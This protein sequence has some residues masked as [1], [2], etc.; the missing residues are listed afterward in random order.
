MPCPD[1]QVPLAPLLGPVSDWG[2]IHPYQPKRLYAPAHPNALQQI[3]SAVIDGEASGGKMK[4]KGSNYS[5]SGAQ[6]TDDFLISTDGLNMH[7]SQ[8]HPVMIGGDGIALLLDASRVANPSY[9]DDLL[10]KIVRPGLVLPPGNHLIHVEAGIKIKQLLADLASVNLALP[11]M[12]AGGGQSLA[13]ALSTGTHGSDVQL[14]PLGD[15]VRAVHIVGPKGQEWWITPADNIVGGPNLDALPGWCPDT[16][17]VRDDDWFRA[18]LLTVGRFGVV[19]SMILE[20]PE[21]YHLLETTN[22]SPGSSAGMQHIL[23]SDTRAQLHASVNQGYDSGGV[24]DAPHQGEPLRFFSVL[25]DL[26]E[27]E[28]CWITRRWKTDDQSEIGISSDPT[29]DDILCSSNPVMVDL[30]IAATAVFQFLGGE[31]LAVP[32]VGLV[33]ASAVAE[34]HTELLVMAANSETVADFLAKAFAKI[35]SLT[36]ELYGPVAPQLQSLIKR[37]GAVLLRGSQTDTRQGASHR[38]LDTHDYNRDGCS[39]G[40]SSEFFFDAQTQNYLLFI[41]AVLNK[42]QELSPVPGYI[43]LRFIRGSKALLAMERFPLTVAIEIAVPRSLSEDN[44]PAFMSAMRDLAMQHGGIPH[45]GQEHKL[46]PSQTEA[47]YADGIDSWRWALA[48]MEG[49]GP[50]TFSSKFCV[51]RGLMATGTI[52]DFRAQRPGGALDSLIMMLMS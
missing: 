3:V 9:G 40:N 25:I 5:L 51:D 12:G 26:A 4:A 38:I 14:S 7:L 45:W 52:D 46:N 1:G 50:Q 22:M 49:D 48:E 30:V 2:N 44:F 8:P 47:L 39:S 21:Q 17:V 27:G 37:L 10:Q 36:T 13:G 11:T 34:L 28:Q 19:Y 29:T 15:F 41:D 6:V 42:A 33:W 16:W 32:V 23:W 43:A 18:A 24:F 31:D 20:V 35:A